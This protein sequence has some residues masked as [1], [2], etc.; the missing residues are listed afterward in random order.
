MSNK[1]LYLQHFCTTERCTPI[2][3]ILDEGN[4]KKL[5]TNEET[6]IDSLMG[7]LGVNFEDDEIAEKEKSSKKKDSKD[8]KNNGGKNSLF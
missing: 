1:W 4:S 7:K 8:T 2:G 3:N 6:K 5:N